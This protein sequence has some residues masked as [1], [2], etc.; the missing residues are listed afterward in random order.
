M[1]T[2]PLLS[3]IASNAFIVLML[4][5]MI[6][7]DKEADNPIKKYGAAYLKPLFLWLGLTAEWKMFS[8]NPPL[9]N[10]WPNIKIYLKNGE[11]M[12]WEPTRGTSLNFI[13]KIRFKKHLK[14]YHEVGQAKT[15]FHIKR[16]FIE[17]LLHKYQ[18]KDRYTKAEVYRVHQ[19]ITPYGQEAD[20]QSKIFKQLIF[21]Y[22]PE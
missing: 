4:F 11:F 21:T 6:C 12:V 3:K 22:N 10:H 16:D 5:W 8:P 7:W 9:Y 17:Y 1:D 18:L 2:L 19:N 20:E 13:E 14:V 15:S